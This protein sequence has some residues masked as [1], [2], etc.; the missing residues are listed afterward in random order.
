[1]VAK[2]DITGDSIQTKGVTD[3]YRNNYDNI[4]RKDKKTDADKFDEQVIMKEEYYDQELED[5]KRQAQEM[6]NDSCTS[7]RKK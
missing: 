3:D 7:P 6:W 4:F 1:M 5:Y 2:N